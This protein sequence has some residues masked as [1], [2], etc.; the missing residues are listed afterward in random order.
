MKTTSP[1]ITDEQRLVAAFTRFGSPLPVYDDGFGPLWIHRG[2]MGITGIVRAQSWH[3]AY[4]ICEDEFFPAGDEDAAEDMAEI[5]ACADA[6]ECGHLQACWEEAYGY[7]NN[8][9]RMPDGTTSGIYAKDLNGDC[10]DQLTPE[11]VA[12]LEITLEIENEE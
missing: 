8:V 9:R 5:E 4:A 2:S 3:D 6:T 7:R 10:L 1:V 11:L 12:E